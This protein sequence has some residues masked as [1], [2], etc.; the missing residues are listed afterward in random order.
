MTRKKQGI[1]V[2]VFT[3][4]VISALIAW[5]LMPKSYEELIPAQ[6]KAVVRIVSAE[7]QNQTN[8]LSTLQNTLGI[9]ADGIDASSPIYAFITPNEY[10]GFVAKTGNE[11]AISNQIARLALQKKCL[12]TEK[13]DNINW[14]WLNSGWLLAWNDRVVWALGPG[15]ASERDL[16]RQTMTSMLETSDCFTKTDA[17]KHLESQGGTMQMF[18]TLD[19]LPTPYNLL[20]RLNIPSDFDPSAIQMFASICTKNN[21]WIVKSNLT[22]EN[23]SIVKALEAKRKENNDNYLSVSSLNNNH[24]FSLATKSTGKQMLQLLKT[25]AT[26]RGLLMALN[27]TIDADKI[28][29][30]CNGLFTLS[31]DSISS[32]WEPSFCLKFDTKANNQFS[33]ADYWMES[34]KKQKEV[35]LKR[36]SPTSY[37]LRSEKQN[38]YFGLNDAN[39]KVYFASPAML[40][41]INEKNTWSTTISN[42]NVTAYFYINLQKLYAQPCM[43]NGASNIIKMLLPG[44]KAVTYIATDGLKSTLIIE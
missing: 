4:V 19:A 42:K 16:L 2:G 1:T 35:D 26:L 20:F 5:W 39:N 30:N 37:Y 17:Y 25:D 31:I 12:P 6:A 24:L 29:S 41:C 9:S 15:V 23:E 22:S 21:E 40:K 44:N 34:A 11:Q 10:I 7:M 14:A 27:Q 33:D 8:A 43:K 13:I 3:T 32:N 36:F 38:V 28:I 18:A